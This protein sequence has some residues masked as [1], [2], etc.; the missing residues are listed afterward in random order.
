MDLEVE[1]ADLHKTRVVEDEPPEAEAGEA[2][3]RVD[4]F[5]LTANNVTY[6]VVGD[7]LRYW[8]FFPTADPDQWGR[9]PVWGFG[10]VMASQVDGVDEGARV[11]GYFPMA[12]HLTVTPGRVSER[13]FA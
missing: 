1:R 5:G 12:T 8:E 2:L 7:T 13:G 11:Y 9:I 3:L 10:D 6:G 4:A